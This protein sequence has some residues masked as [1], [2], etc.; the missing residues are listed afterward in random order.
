MARHYE[1]TKEFKAI[2]KRIK[3]LDSKIKEEGGWT[4]ASK[5]LRTE[6]DELTL[7]L[8][9]MK[10]EHWIKERNDSDKEFHLC[11]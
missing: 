3:E 10:T 1:L 4:S 7:Q 5:A 2:R 8:A 11:S 6:W 9:T